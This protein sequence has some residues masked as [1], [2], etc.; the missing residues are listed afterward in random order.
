[1]AVRAENFA[2]WM[3]TKYSLTGGGS[4]VSSSGTWVRGPSA[5]QPKHWRTL[6]FI[7]L[8]RWRRLQ[9]F[10]RP[11]SISRRLPLHCCYWR[12]ARAQGH[13][14]AGP[15]ARS[16]APDLQWACEALSL[17]KCRCGRCGGRSR[18]RAGRKGGGGAV[19]RQ[20]SSRRGQ[21][22]PVWFSVAVPPPWRARRSDTSSSLKA[23]SSKRQLLELAERGGQTSLAHPAGRTR[24]G[25]G[26]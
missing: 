15:A 25:G 10:R 1:M 24:G 13:S 7:P 2:S 12:G 8:W 6:L 11:A 16:A 18:R 19:R 26:Q 14:S 17:V 20:P 22:E 23:G 5:F 9:A 21:L 4:Q 3:H